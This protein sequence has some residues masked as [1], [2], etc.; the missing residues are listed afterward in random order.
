MSF[1]VLHDKIKSED[2]YLENIFIVSCMLVLIIIFNFCDALHFCTAIDDWMLLC[3]ERLLVFAHDP[4]EQQIDDFFGQRQHSVVPLTPQLGIFGRTGVWCRYKLCSQAERSSLSSRRPTDTVTLLILFLLI[5]AQQKWKHE[6]GRSCYTSKSARTQTSI[7]VRLLTSNAIL[8][9]IRAI[10][11][12]RRESVASSTEASYFSEC[13]SI[14]FLLSRALWLV[15]SRG[16]QGVATVVAVVIG[17][18][19]GRALSPVEHVLVPTLDSAWHWKVVLPT[20]NSNTAHVKRH[21]FLLSLYSVDRQ[22]ML[23]RRLV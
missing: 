19:P 12:S 2:V 9:K 5:K 6:E 22:V 1:V 13:L 18:W 21:V 14:F 10:G 8:A 7:C 20:H 4:R 16:L 17:W 3:L 15:S 11:K 23:Q